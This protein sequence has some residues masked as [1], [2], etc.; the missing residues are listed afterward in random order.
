MPGKDFAFEYKTNAFNRQKVTQHTFYIF[1]SITVI[2]K[3]ME[4][5]KYTISSQN[6]SFNHLRKTNLI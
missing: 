4:L 3:K 5:D 2:Y 1:S 6:R